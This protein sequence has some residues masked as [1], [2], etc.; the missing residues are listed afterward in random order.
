MRARGCHGGSLQHGCSGDERDFCEAP[1][2]M[3][4]GDAEGTRGGPPSLQTYGRTT[5]GGDTWPPEGS[6]G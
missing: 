6:R 4:R 5:W 3:T 1:T 2:L